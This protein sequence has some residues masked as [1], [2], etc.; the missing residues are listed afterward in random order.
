M[1]SVITQHWA[2]NDPGL[3]LLSKVLPMSPTSLLLS[4]PP[5]QSGS[6]VPIALL[7][8]S[9]HVHGGP[10]S[11]PVWRG[12]RAS[13]QPAARAPTQTLPAPDAL[14]FPHSEHMLSKFGLGIEN[15]FRLS[16]YSSTHTACAICFVWSHLR[17]RL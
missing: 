13:S 17:L 4:G 12:Y 9:F 16:T 3:L 6:R 1:F 10:C 8:M 11:C 5:H 14:L 7:H 15:P 2:R